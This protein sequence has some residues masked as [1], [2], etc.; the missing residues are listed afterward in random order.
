MCAIGVR[1]AI[2]AL[3]ADHEAAG[4]LV[5]AAGL[6]AADPSVQ[7]MLADGLAL[8]SAA[9]RPDDPFLAAAPKTARVGARIAARPA[10]SRSGLEAWPKT[11]GD[12]RA[13]ERDRS[14]C[15][16]DQLLHAA[17]M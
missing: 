7:I 16:D 8:E 10:P 9:F 3:H 6:D 13:R 12:G 5:V 15:G 2:V 1:P 4:C 11:A 17:S 14:D